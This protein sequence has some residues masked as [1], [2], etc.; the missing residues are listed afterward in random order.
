VVLETDAV[1]LM[2]TLLARRTDC[3]G[4]ELVDEEV[5]S[6]TDV[7]ERPHDPGTVVAYFERPHPEAIPGIRSAV[8]DALQMIEDAD[9]QVAECERYTDDSWKERWKEYFEPIRLSERIGVG[10]PWRAD[11][12]PEPDGGTA[13]VVE[14]GMAF[15]TGQH[16][17]TRL[18]GRMLD[19]RLGRATSGDSVLDVGCGSGIL[20]MAAAA[21][22]ASE[23]RSIDVDD[24]AVDAVRDNL[25]R[26]GLHGSVD[27]STTPLA[28]I[29]GSY[30]LVVANILAPVLLELRPDLFARVGTGGELLVSGLTVEDEHEFRDEFVPRRW[31]V[32]ERRQLGEWVGLACR[33]DGDSKLES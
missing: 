13:L 28:D 26:N 11:E 7:P 22:G 3:L 24:E 30:E 8:A 9:W 21:L 12:I 5:A 33:R 2:A 18:A 17:T 32:V 23:V 20:S 14:P 31:R 6:R 25:E 10:P 15:G 1:E 16:E 27:P 29:D 4:T 19:D